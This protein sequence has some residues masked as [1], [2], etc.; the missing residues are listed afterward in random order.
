MNR[1]NETLQFPTDA[2]PWHFLGITLGVT[3]LTGFLGVALQGRI[4]RPLVLLL[5]YSGGLSPLAVA[6]WLTY[7]K[8][9][10]P[11]QQK[12]WTRI[13]DIHRIGWTWTAVILLFFPLKSLL[14]ALIDRFLG[15]SGIAP[16]AVSKLIAQPL[17][18]VPTLLFWLF[19]G[20]VPEEP[21]WRGYATD[22]L[23]A[24]TGATRA[25]LVV[26]SVWMLWHLPLFFIEGTWQAE[27]LGFGTTLFGLWAMGVIIESVLYTWI[28]N[29]TQRS[30]FAAILFHFV[31]NAFGQLFALSDRAEFI[32]YGLSIVAV[33]TVIAI[34]GPAHLR[35]PPQP[36][37]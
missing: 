4:P 23:Q 18:I 1:S 25:S 17:T 2:R 5:V 12:F 6:L 14:A 24:Q 7:R 20:P 28:Y 13:V 34:W 8:H 15:G 29:N 36:V 32:N 27:H 3:W 33:L 16:E 31:G 11:R 19:F 35:H 21:G 26:G 9:A 10:R 22:G 37:T 30:I